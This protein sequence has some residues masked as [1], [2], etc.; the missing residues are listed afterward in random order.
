MNSRPGG[1][2][3]EKDDIGGER[4]AG[5]LRRR[6]LSA[7]G[8]VRREEPE[9]KKCQ[10]LK[11]GSGGRSGTRRRAN[12]GAGGGRRRFRGFS[13]EGGGTGTAGQEAAVRLLSSSEESTGWSQD[14]KY[15]ALPGTLRSQICGPE[16]GEPSKLQSATSHRYLPTKPL[17]LK[18][19][20]R[21]PSP[22]RC[23]S[24]GSM[25]G[26]PLLLLAT[27]PLMML[28]AASATAQP[29]MLAD[30]V[31]IPLIA[32]SFGPNQKEI[33]ADGSNVI[34][35]RKLLAGFT[36][37]RGEEHKGDDIGCYNSVTAQTMA[38]KCQSDSRCQGFNIYNGNQGCY[39]TSSSISQKI[40]L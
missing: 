35:N 29:G 40:A 39:K 34:N 15:S 12:K 23:S 26:L 2:D 5:C 11:D 9:R 30:T 7:V 16:L 8:R 6:E 19:C 13:Q 25:L 32:T 38:S 21:T 3:E 22:R 10:R 37:T 20:I 14:D 17:P 4:L 33:G 31:E 28:S 1:K 27:I 24:A 36:F 18:M